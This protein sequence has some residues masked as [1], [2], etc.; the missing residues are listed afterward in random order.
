MMRLLLLILTI[1]MLSASVVYA[2]DNNREQVCAEFIKLVQSEQFEEAKQ[3]YISNKQILA[4]NSGIEALTCWLY[5]RLLTNDKDV[6]GAL[7]YLDN[8]IR[9]LDANY[10]ELVSLKRFDF[11]IPYYDHAHI[12]K[13]IDHPKAKERYL[14]AKRVFEEAE[15]TQEIYLT[16]F[17][18]PATGT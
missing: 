10:S 18:H 3:Y 1:V 4:D 5:A 9:I 2:Q 11:V 8:S 15:I 12:S 6:N 13:I 7:H 17:F 14:K 16:T